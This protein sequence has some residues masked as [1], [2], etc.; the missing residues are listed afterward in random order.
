MLGRVAKM[1]EAGRA[2]VVVA[3]K[4][5]AETSEQ[6]CARWQVEHPGEDPD[7]AGLKVILISWLDPQPNAA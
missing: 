1:E 2:G 5:S 4:Y 7:K 3:W 6:A